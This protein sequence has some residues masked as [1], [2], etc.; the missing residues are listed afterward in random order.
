MYFWISDKILSQNVYSSIILRYTLRH[1]YVAVSVAMI[2]NIDKCIFPPS[3][4]EVSH[5]WSQ[6]GCQAEPSVV[7][8]D[9]Q[10]EYVGQGELHEV[11]SSQHQVA[12]GKHSRLNYFH[13]IAG[14]LKKKQNKL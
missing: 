6:D 8:H 9:N 13:R 11:Q 14:G 10:H 3:K 4:E 5:C 12:D 2:R 7:R 1:I